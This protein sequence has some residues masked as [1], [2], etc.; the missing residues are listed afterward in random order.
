MRKFTASE[1]VDRL[2]EYGVDPDHPRPGSEDDPWRK[3]GLK[4][5]QFKAK[6][7]TGSR[8]TAAATAA[9]EE[10][11]EDEPAKKDRFKWKPPV[12]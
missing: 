7:F 1:V 4:K 9:P 10:E 2:L 11:D 8:G 12:E 3:G 6:D 5:M